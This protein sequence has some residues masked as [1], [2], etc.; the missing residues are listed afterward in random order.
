[1]REYL[2]HGSCQKDYSY[3]LEGKDLL[4]YYR[5]TSNSNLPVA[6]PKVTSE[7]TKQ[8]YHCIMFPSGGLFAFRESEFS[9]EAKNL[10]RRF[11]DVFQLTFTRHLDLRKAEAQNKIIQA[12]NERKTKE[13]EDARQL[14][15][16]MLPRELPKVSNLDIAVYMK[17]A[18]EVGGDYYDFHVQPDGTLNCSCW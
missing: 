9:T 12:E 5:V 13:L 6:A 11:A 14:Q 15:L 18:T 7:T 4:D 10:M 8:Y 1:M 17:T 16:S 2:R 3:V